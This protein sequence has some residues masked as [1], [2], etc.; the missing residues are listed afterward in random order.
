M[1]MIWNCPRCC[2]RAS[3]GHRVTTRSSLNSTAS[4]SA[5]CLGFVEVVQDG[6]FIAIVAE[7]EAD[8]VAALET[9][10]AMPPSGLTLTSCRPRTIPT[11]TCCEKPAQSNL[12]IDGVAVVDPIPAIEKPAVAEQTHRATYHRPFQMHASL[13]PSAAVALWQDG[14]LT[15][16]TH[17]QAVFS[18]RGALAQ[19]LALDEAK[20]RVIHVEGAG[21]Y[22]HNGADDAA[23]DAA[24]VARAMPDRPISLKWTRWDEHAR[25]PYG[26]AMVMQLGASLSEP[27]DIID[28]QHEVWSYAH[29]TRP[30]VGFE[31]SGL[32]AARHLA[33]PFAPPKAEADGW[34]PL[35]CAPQC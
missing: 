34:R 21:C 35:R 20:I 30:A 23:L 16:W 13:G 18:L 4:V 5:A 22:G 33:Q 31:T 25:E 7:R 32:L 26:T 10:R 29:S 24:L 1:Y 12:I 11:A 17:S 28:W 2:T 6:Q 27:G 15:V 3:C 8:A 9:W 19:V 14:A